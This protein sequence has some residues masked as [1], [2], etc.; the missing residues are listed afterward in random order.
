MCS[1]IYICEHKN[2]KEM[3]P[4]TK[5]TDTVIKAVWMQASTTSDLK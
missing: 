1:R 2:Y 5:E 3:A 4:I